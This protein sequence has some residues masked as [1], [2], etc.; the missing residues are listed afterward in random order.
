MVIRRPPASAFRLTPP[1]HPTLP[2]SSPPCGRVLQAV[3]LQPFVWQLRKHRQ[4]TP[5]PAHRTLEGLHA[6]FFGG[7]HA[8]R[9]G[10]APVRGAGL[11][12]PL[13]EG[14]LARGIAHGDD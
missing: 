2:R 9:V 1:S 6:L 5:E 14:F 10:V 12:G 3:D 11:A 7:E 4:A 13:G 8:H